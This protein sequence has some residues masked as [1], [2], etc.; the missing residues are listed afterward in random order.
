MTKSRSERAKKP[1]VYISGPI[2]IGDT[3]RNTYWACMEWHALLANELCVPICPH[4]SVVQQLVMP[5]THDD[6]IDYDLDLL[7]RCDAMLRLPGESKGADAEEAFCR[8]NDIPV[9]TRHNELIQW[10][11]DR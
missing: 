8:E 3:C 7:S 11:D 10:L 6:W 2:T 9:F 1:W 4:W 5:L